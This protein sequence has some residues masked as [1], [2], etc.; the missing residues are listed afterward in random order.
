MLKV[1]PCPLLKNCSKSRTCSTPGPAEAVAEFLQG[2]KE[3]N[4]S[5]ILSLFCSKDER[6]HLGPLGKPH[7][8]G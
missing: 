6:W 3:G 8:R 5:G 1:E 7:L 2:S 4:A